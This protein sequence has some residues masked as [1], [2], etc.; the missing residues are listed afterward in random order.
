ML[1]AGM[2][3]SLK[4]DWETPEDFFRALDEE[5]HFDLDACARKN[6][7]LCARYCEDALQPWPQFSAA[8]MN[9]PYGRVIGRFV[10]A[11]YKAASPEH[12]VVC[13]LPSRTDTRWFHAFCKK[14]ELRFVK[15]R[16]RFRG[17]KAPAP[18]PSLVVVFR[19]QDAPQ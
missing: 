4:D 7:R 5:F 9:P 8:F 12:P 2:M 19:G 18:F 16:L 1:N 13:L 3:S 10:E 6:N 15:G 11:A 17:A 14:G